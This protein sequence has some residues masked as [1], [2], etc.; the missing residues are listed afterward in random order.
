MP[1]CRASVTSTDTSEISR[2]ASRV[3]EELSRGCPRLRLLTINTPRLCRMIS[4]EYRLTIDPIAG[5]AAARGA[6]SYAF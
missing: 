5:L 4:G 2:Q 3:A 1:P 6:R